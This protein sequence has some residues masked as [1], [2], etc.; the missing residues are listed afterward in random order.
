MSATQR[1][2][3]PTRLLRGPR[4]GVVAWSAR[5]Q[6][7][8][9]ANDVTAAIVRVSTLSTQVQAVARRNQSLGVSVGVAQKK[10]AVRDAGLAPLASRVLQSVFTIETDR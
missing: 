8:K 7:R 3:A 9:A 5:S 6:A 10:L 2:E 1:F 4:P